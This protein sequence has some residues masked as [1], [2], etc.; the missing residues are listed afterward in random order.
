MNEAKWTTAS[1]L[2][3][4]EPHRRAHRTDTLRAFLATHGDVL[5]NMSGRATR[6][7]PSSAATSA[8]TS[9]LSAL[10]AMGG[11]KFKNGQKRLRR[12]VGHHVEPDVW[13]FTGSPDRS[14]SLQLTRAPGRDAVWAKL[15]PSEAVTGSRAARPGFGRIPRQTSP[16]GPAIRWVQPVPAMTR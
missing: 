8:A 15:M 16:G 10:Q 13:L 3:S 1:K 5:S 2:S 14:V 6:H 4:S 9:K 12:H 11:A 7:G